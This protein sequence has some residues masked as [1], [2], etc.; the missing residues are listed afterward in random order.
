[1]SQQPQIDAAKAPVIAY[2]KK[3][4]DAVKA[5][6]APDVVYDE[7]AT[8]RKVQGVDPVIALWKG[9]ATALPDS[10]ATFHE[11]FVSGDTVVLEVTWRGKHTGP[12]QTPTG[13]IP[14]TGKSIELR[15][16]Q[17]FEIANGKA[18]SMRQYFDMATLMQQ[19]GVSA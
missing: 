10:K 1:M 2:G 16:C 17:V 18:Q 15:A 8:N 9:W 5:A 11:A 13:Q 3:D 7:V 12:L 19:L 6:V 4:W 14:A